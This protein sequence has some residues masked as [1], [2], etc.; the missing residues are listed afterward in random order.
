MRANRDACVRVLCCLA[1]LE[2]VTNPVESCVK[3]T[4]SVELSWAENNVE[5]CGLCHV[6]HVVVT[7]LVCI[8]TLINAVTN[9][10]SID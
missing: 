2:C 9:I 10:P 5:E 6:G 1:E 3:L 8:G 4:N 7:I